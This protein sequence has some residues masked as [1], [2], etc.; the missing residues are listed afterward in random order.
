MSKALK[1]TFETE[2]STK[3]ISITNPKEDVD[4]D[5]CKAAMDTI[6]ESG[7]F[8]GITGAVKAVMHET[9]SEIIYEA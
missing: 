5:T 3:T 9:N 6:V 2:D 8:D 7:A 1:L 4:Q